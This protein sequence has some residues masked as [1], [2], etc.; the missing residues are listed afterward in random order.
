MFIYEDFAGIWTTILR[1][2]KC[3]YCYYFQVSSSVIWLNKANQENS[4]EHQA[5]ISRLYKFY[6]RNASSVRTI[7]VANCLTPDLSSNFPNVEQMEEK[8]QEKEEV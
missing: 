3:Y 6:N 8:P 7:L 2:F 1:Y 4:S 5:I